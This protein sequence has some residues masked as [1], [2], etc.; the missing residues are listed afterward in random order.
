MELYD[1][2]KQIIV[3]GDTYFHIGDVLVHVE[4]ISDYLLNGYGIDTYEMSDEEV[5]KLVEKE[6]GDAYVKR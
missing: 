6:Y 3:A 4:N 2:F 1:T 5:K